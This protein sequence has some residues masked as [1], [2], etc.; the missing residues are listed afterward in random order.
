MQSYY[1]P[2]FTR[3]LNSKNIFRP[4]LIIDDYIL[5]SFVWKEEVIIIILCGA[6]GPE[7]RKT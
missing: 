2:I 6:G 4:S 5:V 3:V 1:F 7:A